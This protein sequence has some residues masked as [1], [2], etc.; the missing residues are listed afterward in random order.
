MAFEHVAQEWGYARTMGGTVLVAGSRVYPTSHD[1]RSLYVVQ[2]IRER[3]IGV[4]MLDGEGV[5]LVHDLA[6]PLPFADV[7]HVDCCSVLEHCADPFAV[8]RNLYAAMVPGA[9]IL[10]SVPFCWRVHA[11]P[12]DYWRFT[13]EGIRQL[14]PGIEWARLVYVY[15]GKE[16][17]RFKVSEEEKALKLPRLPKC[18]V[19]GWGWKR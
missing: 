19:V 4:D 13:C 14:F 2:P 16:S 12:S 10:V 17:Q 3:V 18:E 11:Y 6:K 7:T 5:D 15:D 8:A 9:S 1:R